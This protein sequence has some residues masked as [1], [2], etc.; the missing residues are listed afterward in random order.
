MPDAITVV[1]HLT[2][3]IYQGAIRPGGPALFAALT[4]AASG[5]PAHIVSVV[6]ENFAFADLLFGPTTATLHTSAKTTTFRNY[7]RYQK[8]ER[9]QYILSLARRFDP[10]ILDECRG[11]IV[12]IVPAAGELSV[13]ECGALVHHAE[14][15]SV[16]LQGFLVPHRLGPVRTEPNGSLPGS[17]DLVFCSVE[18]LDPFPG[19]LN[20]IRERSRV[21]V[22]TN[23][24]KGSTIFDGSRTTQCGASV[25]RCVDPTGAGDTFA[26]RFLSAV[27]GGSSLVNAAAEAAWWSARVV[28]AEGPTSLVKLLGDDAAKHCLVHSNETVSRVVPCRHLRRDELR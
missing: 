7:Y 6:G 5:R 27:V 18:D 12:H 25:A 22:V 4:L 20:E 3:D 8:Y 23:G 14:L 17:L 2:H 24:E 26:A 10:A 28:E 15:S 11:S 19:L 9:Y 16:G 13:K 1:G 21:V